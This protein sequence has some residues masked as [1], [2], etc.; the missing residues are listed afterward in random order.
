MMKSKIIK[1]FGIILIIIFLLYLFGFILQT[2]NKNE[3]KKYIKDVTGIDI[4]ECKEINYDESHGG[5]MGDGDSYIEWDCSNTEINLNGDEM[6]P[7]PL[8]EKLNIVLYETEKDGTVYSYNYGG[9]HGIP[10][11]ENGYYYFYDDYCETYKDISNCKSDENLLG[12]RAAFNF[13]FIAFDKD[14]NR[15]YYLEVDT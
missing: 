15:L 7:Y 6:L 4:K 5:F 8:T 10:K 14:T 11:I 2:I 9:D 1:I 12:V 13:T 3:F